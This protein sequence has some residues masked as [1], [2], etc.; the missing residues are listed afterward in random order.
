VTPMLFFLA[1]KNLSEIDKKHIAKLCVAMA[2]FS[3][4]LFSSKIVNRIHSYDFIYF[5]LREEFI[6]TEEMLKKI[7]MDASV[8]ASTFLVPHL[9][10]REE[11]YKADLFE[12]DYFYYN[13]DYLINDLRGV[14]VE[15]YRYFLEEIRERGYK[16]IDESPF[17]EVFIKETAD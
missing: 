2:C 9:I 12:Y 13:T 7:P 10:K 8:S 14:D 4:V 6:E 16:K 1:V 17:V 11:V 5:N 3:A 15:Q